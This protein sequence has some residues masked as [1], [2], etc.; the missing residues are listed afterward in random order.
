[1]AAML[2]TLGWIAIAFALAHALG[3][4]VATLL[5]PRDHDDSRWAAMPT[6]GFALLCLAGVS[7]SSNFGLAAPKAAVGAT[8][9]RVM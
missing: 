4:G 7:L 6:I 8:H 5:W 1:M 2:E 9:D 3:Y